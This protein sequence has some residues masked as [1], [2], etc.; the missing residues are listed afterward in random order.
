MNVSIHLFKN[1]SLFFH[2]C[3]SY[4]LNTNIELP[5]EHGFQSII[6]S[7]QFQVNNLRCASAGKDNVIKLWTIWDSENIYKRGIMWSCVAQANYKQQ[8]LESMCFSQDG[9]ILAAGYGHTLVLFD[10]RSLRLLHALSTSAGYDGVLAKAQLRLSQTPINGTRSELTQQRQQLWNLLQ[11]LL[12]SNDQKLIQQAQ[13]LMASAPS[14]QG[15]DSGKQATKETVYKHIM[16]MSELGLHQ[17]LQLLR[18]FG[19]E[20]KVHAS[21]Q[22]RL[23]SHLQRCVVDPLAAQTRLRTIKDRLLRLQPCQRFKAKQRLVRLKKRRKTT[24]IW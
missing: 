5:H 16:Q 12:N 18:R 6:F 22:V 4:Q 1:N 15:K 13:Q 19:I 10:A 21:C 9:S 24:K 2:L 23:R 20:C 14:G 11:T 7:N 8:A 3:C 17:K